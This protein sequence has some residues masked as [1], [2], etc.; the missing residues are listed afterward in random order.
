MKYKK[1]TPILILCI[2]L[3]YSICSFAQDSRFME[4]F[5]QR[6][7]SE[8]AKFIPFKGKSIQYVIMPPDNWPIMYS[9]IADSIYDLDLT[10][11]EQVISSSFSHNEYYTP[12][13]S[14]GEYEL[15]EE[16]YGNDKDTFEAFN[17]Y[18]MC[19]IDNYNNVAGLFSVTET[20]LLSDGTKIE[21]SHVDFI[22][23]LYVKEK[24]LQDHDSNGIEAWRYSA[25]HACVPLIFNVIPQK[26]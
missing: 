13:L 26:K 7:E 23:I 1:Y 11:I 14:F 19:L 8:K 2:T 6:K 24:F 25:K 21:R 12:N 22:G 3:F 20:F 4:D 10:S 15:C 18:W 16:L 5:P 17:E 9:I